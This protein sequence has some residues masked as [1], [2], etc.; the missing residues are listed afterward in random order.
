MEF[1]SIRQNRWKSTFNSW[2]ARRSCCSN[3]CTLET[4]ESDCSPSPPPSVARRTSVQSHNM[5]IQWWQCMFSCHVTCS[6]VFRPYLSL[7]YFSTLCLSTLGKC[8]HDKCRVTNRV[9]GSRDF[10]VWQRSSYLF[11]LQGV[12][13]FWPFMGL[14]LLRQ[15]HSRRVT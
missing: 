4:C 10:V 3:S 15:S 12:L 14:S 9:I 8:P 5:H 1:C 11:F 2:S 13:G 6:F 7:P